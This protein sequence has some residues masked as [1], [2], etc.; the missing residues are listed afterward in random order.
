VR[1]ASA[2][3]LCLVLALASGS[4]AAGPAPSVADF[5]GIW[6]VGKVLGAS[7]GGLTA[8]DPKKLIGK[9][10]HWS[11]VEVQ[12]PEGTCHLRG[13]TVLPIENR[14]L[15]TSV[16]GGQTIADLDLPEQSLAK[17]FGK[18]ATPVFQDDS[19]CANAVM[20]DRNHLASGFSNGWIY[21]LDRVRR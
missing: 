13:P 12:S 15:E 21:R 17:A 7:E 14:L 2:R 20:L 4:A 16:W 6:R 1:T 5:T 9:M 8:D 18:T 11:A 10:V 3:G 19:G